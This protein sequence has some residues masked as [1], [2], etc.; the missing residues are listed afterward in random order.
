M[1][2]TIHAR[3]TSMYEEDPTTLTKYTRQH[4]LDVFDA[5]HNRESFRNQTIDMFPER[6]LPVSLQ[7]K[8]AQRVDIN[9]DSDA[10]SSEP[11]NDDGP[12]QQIGD[13]HSSGLSPLAAYDNDFP[14]DN[15]GGLIN[16]D[17]EEE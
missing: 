3:L 5:L 1:Q 10:A 7:Y 4:L 16:D 13:S 9:Q 15:D 12:E 14:S 8:K 2:L 6:E 11:E 17:E